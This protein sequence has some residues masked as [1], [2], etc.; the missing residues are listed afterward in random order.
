MSTN[1][2][3]S[4]NW[5]YATKRF[6]ASKKVSTDDLTTLKTA[7]NLTATSY[8][9]QPFRVLVSDDA[10]LKA[11]LRE[12]SYNQPQLTESSHVF[13]FASKLDM[14]P[15]Y[16]ENFIRLVAKTRNVPYDKLSGYGDYIK[17]SVAAQDAD[18]VK[19]WNR[20]QAYI[21]LGTLLA[22][23]AELR[24]DACPMEGFDAAQYN[25]ILG[26]PE[27]GL[28]AAVVATIGYRSDEDHTSGAAKVRL[29]LGEMFL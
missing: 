20:N 29:P 13:V 16:I 22:T 1:L 11:K 18:A 23:A 19:A 27:K 15:E 8:G 26:L 9:L 24:I 6:D 28:T 25:D 12:A 14:T 21:A 7:V 10:E 5:R 3:E 4:L 2:I 17:G